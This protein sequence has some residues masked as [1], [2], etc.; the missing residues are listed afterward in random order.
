MNEAVLVFQECVSFLSLSGW[1]LFPSLGF[2]SSLGFYACPQLSSECEG[3]PHVL[4]PGGSFQGHWQDCGTH[5][6]GLMGL[7]FTL[8]GTSLPSLKKESGF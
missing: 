1:S 3:L 6:L 2:S 7:T 8:G 4:A 5:D